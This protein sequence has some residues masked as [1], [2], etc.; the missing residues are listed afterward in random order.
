MFDR[1]PARAATGLSMT[2]TLATAA[3]CLLVLSGCASARALLFPTATP[4][5][6]STPAPS[7]TPTATATA[8]VTQTPSPTPTPTLTHT[9]SPTHTPS[10]TA[11]ATSTPSAT[12]SPTATATPVPQPTPDGVTR[13]MHVPILVYHYVSVPPADADAYRRDLSVTPAQL[14]EHL[15]YLREAGYTGITLRELTLALQMGY[16][17]P[18]KPIV[19]TFD[20]GYRD[21][22][23]NAFPLLQRYGYAGTFFLITSMADVGHP[24]Y[25]TWE[26]VSAMH[27]AGMDM[28]AHCYSHVDL[29]NRSIDYLVW[30]VLGSKEA[31]EA[32]TGAPVRF[33]CYP[34]GKYDARVI[35][36]LHSAGYWG[37][38]T[39]IEGAEHRSDA[40]F[41]LQ[42]IRVRGAYDTATL[43]RRLENVT[44]AP[45]GAQ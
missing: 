8:T 33:F 43:V 45:D 5:A 18:A 13:T 39:L 1:R 3:V 40:L 44:R 17:L 28:Q 42:R 24:A 22:Y 23:E 11:T 6:T 37:A 19:L 15:Q 2:L 10:R 20:D 9:P 30:Q 21:A 32:R 12:P 36:V 4:T 25:L 27:A 29:R 35:E 14:E 41:E 16:P 38:V 34:S 7:A 31:I 26:Q